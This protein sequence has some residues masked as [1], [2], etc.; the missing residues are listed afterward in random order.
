MVKSSGSF[1][2]WNGWRCVRFLSQDERIDIADLRQ[3]GLSV[4]QIAVHDLA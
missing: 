3:A 2:R 1:P 4:R